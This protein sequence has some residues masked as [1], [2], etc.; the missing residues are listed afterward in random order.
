M[1]TAEKPLV[2]TSPV[3]SLFERVVVGV[4]G[5]EPGYEAAR[6]AARLVEPEGTL[7]LFTAVRLADA[8]L[9]GWSAPRLEAQLWA[10]AEEAARHAALI[11]GPRAETK[12]VNGPALFSLERELVELEATLVVVG[13]HG[14]KRLPQIVLGGVATDLLHNAPCSVCIARPPAIDALFPRTIVAGYDGSP[15]SEAAVAVAQRLAERFAGSARLVTASGGKHVDVAAAETRGATV[16]DARP[17]TAL[18]EAG[19]DADLIVLGSRGL[20]GLK[21]LGSVSERVAHQARCS[22]LVVRPHI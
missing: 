1:S 16:V 20:H 3:R 13:T 18:V 9:A 21:A 14:F 7:E 4:D 11:A 6:Q 8:A 5:S 2:R 12:L 22:V 15:A 19:A 17:V 10:E